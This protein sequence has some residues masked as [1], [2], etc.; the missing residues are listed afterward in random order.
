M[1]MREKTKKIRQT[2]EQG[3]LIEGKMKE[4]CYKIHDNV[5]NISELFK[6]C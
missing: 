3:K 2:D 5:M 1:I 6:R 4:T